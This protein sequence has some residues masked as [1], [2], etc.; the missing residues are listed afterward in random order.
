MVTPQDINDGLFQYHNEGFPMLQLDPENDPVGT[1][2]MALFMV[3]I[4]VMFLYGD[5]ILKFFQ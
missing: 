2:V 4:S 5:Y 1:V 3:I